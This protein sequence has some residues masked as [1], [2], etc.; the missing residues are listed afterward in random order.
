MDASGSA[1]PA[2][3]ITDYKWDFAGTGN[4]SVDTGATGTATHTFSVPGISRI[5]VQVTRSGGVV[6]T[7]Y[8]TVRVIPPPPPGNLGIS[9]D[10]GDYATNNPHV[11][12]D[13]IWPRGATQALISNDGGFNRAGGTKSEDLAVVLPWTLEQTG[14]DRLPKTAYV[15]FLGAGVDYV[16]FTDDIIFDETAP[17]LSS[18]ALVSTA[19]AASASIA[20]AKPKRKPLHKYR[21]RLKARDAIAGICE[22]QA[23]TVRRGGTT[24]V[25]TSCRKKGIS[26]LVRVVPVRARARP[27]YVRVR[28]SA[29]S[30]SRWRRVR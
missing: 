20:R 10:T 14:K 4:F 26:R 19:R 24:T 13:L 28:N 25:I 2:S 9:I 18:A 17:S 8:T 23:S 15:R 1:L 29:G 11:S 5:G 12:L 21:L 7:A 6:D 27:R 30:W 3:T 16:T 22:V